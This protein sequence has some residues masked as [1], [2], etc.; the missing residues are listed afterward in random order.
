MMADGQDYKLY[1]LYLE[2]GVIVTYRCCEYCTWAAQTNQMMA[3]GQEYKLY[4]LYL[5]T[6]VIVTY[7]CC[8]YSTWAK[9]IRLWLMGR[10]TNC[11]CCTEQA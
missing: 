2:A 7:R 11:T 6:G 3:D 10:S 5:E 1:V 9:Q 4:V 8:E